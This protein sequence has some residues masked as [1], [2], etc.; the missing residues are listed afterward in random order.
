M[1]P[2]PFSFVAPQATGLANID[3]VYSM[4]FD[5][6]DDTI[7]TNLNLAYTVH[8]NITASFWIKINPSDVTAFNIYYPIGIEAGAFVNGSVGRLYADSASSVKVIIQGQSGI[9]LSTTNLADN[10]WHNTI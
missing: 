1:F 5:G 8:P 7:V 4:S 9:T 10:N 3:N 6:V 2:F